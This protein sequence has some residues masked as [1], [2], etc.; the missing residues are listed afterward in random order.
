MS[1]WL[2]KTSCRR[3]IGDLPNTKLV[4]NLPQEL[5]S[6][7]IIWWRGLSCTSNIPDIFI[8]THINTTFAKRNHS[9]FDVHVSVCLF[10]V[11]SQSQISLHLDFFFFSVYTGQPLILQCLVQVCV[12]TACVSVCA[13]A[14]VH[15][16]QLSI[17]MAEMICS[18]LYAN[19]CFWACS[20]CFSASM[21]WNTHGNRRM[22]TDCETISTYSTYDV[23]ST[24]LTK[25]STQTFGITT[26]L[27]I[28]LSPARH[29]Q[30]LNMCCSAL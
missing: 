21:I 1:P 19:F 17:D 26:E 8:L 4:W 23:F 2:F 29:L 28:E 22:W 12:Y 5:R 3:E 15:T 13:S 14:C 24:M 11:C 6:V 18:T 20:S 30:W 7:G 9:R 25:N 16:T 27:Q 10:C